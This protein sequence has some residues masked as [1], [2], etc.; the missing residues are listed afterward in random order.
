MVSSQV[1]G[2]FHHYLGERHMGVSNEIKGWP[3]K[4][5]YTVCIYIY[6]YVPILCW[7][8]VWIIS[9]ISVVCGRQWLVD[10]LKH[11]GMPWPYQQSHPKKHTFHPHRSANFM[12]KHVFWWYTYFNLQLQCGNGTDFKSVIYVTNKSYTAIMLGPAHARQC[13]CSR[14]HEAQELGP[15]QLK[16]TDDYFPTVLGRV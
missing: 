14:F 11:S 4:K 5:Q 7:I 3:N 12:F 2:K 15:K 10:L 1:C 9:S 8:V 6:M 16:K 13:S